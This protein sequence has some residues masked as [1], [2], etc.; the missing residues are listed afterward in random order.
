MPYFK[1]TT[2]HKI[3]TTESFV[4]EAGDAAS[5]MRIM[6]ERMAQKKQLGV[7]L[8]REN[9]PAA[10]LRT[11]MSLDEVS[12]KEALGLTSPELFRQ[13]ESILGPESAQFVS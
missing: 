12:E 3:V 5:A 9:R 11:V 7:R 10:D 2:A 8:Y 4:I 1:V 13:I 6:K